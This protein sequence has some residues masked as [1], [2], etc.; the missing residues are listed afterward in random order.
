MEASLANAELTI[1]A[2][3]CDLLMPHGP[4]DPCSMAARDMAVLCQNS[5][6]KVGTSR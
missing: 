1:L 4:Q 6:I 2:K 3:I 5:I